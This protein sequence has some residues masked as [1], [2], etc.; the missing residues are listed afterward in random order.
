MLKPPSPTRPTVSLGGP[1][2]AR[3]GER[4]ALR[5]AGLHG[6]LG[7]RE[8]ERRLARAGRPAIT[9]CLPVGE[10]GDHGRVDG[11]GAA[12]ARRLG[13]GPDRRDVEEAAGRARGRRPRAPP[14]RRAPRAR[15]LEPG[16]FG[17]HFSAKSPASTAG[18]SGA[19][20]PR[21]DGCLGGRG[22]AVTDGDLVGASP[23]AGPRCR[24]R[25]RRRAPRTA[26]GERRRRGAVATSASSSASM[27][28]SSASVSARPPRRSRPPRRRQARRVGSSASSAGSPTT[29]SGASSAGRRHPHRSS[30]A[31]RGR[32]LAA[33]SGR[34]T[35]LRARSAAT[36][37][38]GRGVAAVTLPRAGRR[39]SS[40]RRRRTPPRGSS[41]GSGAAGGRIPR[42]RPPRPARG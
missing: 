37:S 13:G 22:R 15:L 6:G 2:R 7:D 41:A 10:R 38:A 40:R 23:A 25:R 29:G 26:G 35:R 27:A 8:R 33:T 28:G 12:S 30:R 3:G 11:V 5:A 4:R 20:R 17:L 19:P 21:G 36:G 42:P 39:R 9:T 31:P 24:P 14:R 32:A 18:S 34:P 1:L 16:H